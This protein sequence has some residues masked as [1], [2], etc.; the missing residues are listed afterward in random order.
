[1]NT[2]FKYKLEPYKS[3]ASRHKCPQCGKSNNFARYID[4]DGNYL[5]D[6]IGRCNSEVRCAYH[7]P[8]QGN[9]IIV[10]DFK[11]E[12]LKPTFLRAKDITKRQ[13]QDNL[14][15]FL[16]G[17]YGSKNVKDVFKRYLVR[18]NHSKWD[19]STVFYQKDKDGNFRTGKIILY[20]SLLGKRVKEPY[21]HIYWVHNRIKEFDFV[22]E[23]CLFGEHLLEEFNHEEHNIY[24]VESEKTCLICSLHFPDDLFLATGGLSNLSPKKLKVLKGYDVQAI[25]DKG[26]Y[27]YWKDKLEPLGITVNTLMEESDAND[28]DDIADLL[29]KKK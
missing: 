15:T 20:D 24:L 5:G 28:G 6:D 12:P 4:S 18:S 13:F 16:S 7:K 25:P 27:D 19:N 14:F 21:S 2:G 8:P 22:L 1:M 9:E 29:I 26:G 11:Y 10:G 17:I 23:Q 3:S